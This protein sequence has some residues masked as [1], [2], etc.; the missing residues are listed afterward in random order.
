MPQRNVDPVLAASFS[1][2]SLQHLISR[3]VDPLDSQ[4]VSVTYVR[5][6]STLNVIP[7]YVEFGGTLRSL[8]SDG[9]HRLQQR[10]KEV[11]EQQASVHRCKALFDLKEE[12]H[13][14]YPAVTNDERLHE[15]VKRV[16]KLLL[17]PKN[18]MIG[19]KVMAGEDFA[20]YQEM[21]PG[22]MF[23]IGIGNEEAGQVL[24]SNPPT[25]LLLCYNLELELDRKWSREGS[26]LICI[27]LLLRFLS[28]PASLS[29]RHELY[30]YL[31]KLLLSGDSDGDW[32]EETPDFCLWRTI[33]TLDLIPLTKTT[34]KLQDDNLEGLFHIT[35]E[36]FRIRNHIRVKC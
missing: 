6:G 5:G 30:D 36:L 31:I 7:S 17:G 8:T 10:V 1:I 35:A 28:L 33:I 12:V 4:V 24:G 14:M 21:I 32:R 15:H 18:V 20:F 27:G 26:A 29:R 3:E 23:G 13:P 9:L 11:I 22:V 25:P 2:L 34:F 16:G 19:R